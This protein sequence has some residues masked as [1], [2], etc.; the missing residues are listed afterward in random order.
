MIARILAAHTRQWPRWITFWP[1]FIV[2]ARPRPGQ[3]DP[4]LDRAARLLRRC[5]IYPRGHAPIWSWIW[6]PWPFVIINVPRRQAH[7]A[8][9]TL[10][11]YGY[12]I[13]G[14]RLTP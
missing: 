5:N 10:I 3:T 12:R 14:R 9:A 7:R 11:R 8:E 1:L 4:T 6:A 13:G 2:R